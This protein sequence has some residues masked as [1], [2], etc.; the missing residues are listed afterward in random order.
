MTPKRSRK[1][2]AGDAQVHLALPPQHGVVSL[3]ILHDDERGIL[4]VQ[5]HQRL[6]ELDVVLAVGGRNRHGEHRWRR[7]RR[8]EC[9]RRGLAARHGVARLDGI[10]LGQRHGVTGFG[11]GPLAVVSAA[12]R[13][14]AGDTARCTG[15]GLQR[16]T[17]VEMAGEQPRQRQLSSVLRV[18]R[19]EHEA[20]R[21]LGLGRAETFCGLRDSRRLV[22]QRLHQAQHAVFARGGTE[23]HGTDQP[24]AQFAGKIVEHRI[25]RRLDVLEQLLH[26]RIVVIGELLQHREARFLLPIEIASV[27]RDHFGGP[28]LAINER[29]F[30][31]EIDKA[32]D[33]LV[34]PDRDLAQHQRHARSGLEHRERLTDAL[35]GAV[36]LVQEQETRNL[37][38]LQLAQDDLQLR[39]LLLVGLADHDGGVDRGQSGAHVVGELNGPGTIQESVAVA[40]EVRARGS[41]PDGHLV[42]TRLGR[43]VADGRSGID[44]AGAGDCARTRQDRFEKCGFTCLERA[45][46]RNAPWTSGTSDVLSHSPPPWCGARPMIGSASADALPLP[47]IWQ[48]SNVA[49]V[50]RQFD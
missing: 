1:P 21:V 10:E 40:H 36:D 22:A 41:E 8:R 12:H 44:T 30:Q 13:E 49:A 17:V 43:G 33:Q 34:F 2:L 32:F 45:H 35:V 23:Q 3:G 26:Q 4:F 6:T 50:R 48:A 47:E 19:L 16:G 42:L 20:E 28:V 25:T 14:D 24:F 27:E 31:C 39:Q 11:R 7:L 38:L 29:T 46:Q 37:Q 15:G 5:P 18:Q 9:S